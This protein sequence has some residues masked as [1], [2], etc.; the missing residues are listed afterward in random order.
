MKHVRQT[1]KQNMKHKLNHHDWPVRIATKRCVVGL[2]AAAA[3]FTALPGA[4]AQTP[5]AASQA[6]ATNAQT[7]A[8]YALALLKK[9]ADKLSAA[10]S[11]TVKTVSSAESP[12][13]D[14][15]MITYF[16]T[17]A[18][19]V[20][21]PNKLMVKRTGDGP[22][23]DLYY[24]GKIFGGVD[25]KLGLYARMDAPPTLDG[26][27]SAVMEKTGMSLPYGD[28]L[29]RDVFA[30][31]TN[32]LTYADAVGQVTINGVPCE[33]LIFAG[34][35]IEW[36]IWLGPE[37]DPLPRRMAVTYLDVER[38]PRFLMNFSDWNLKARLAAS[39]FELKPPSGAKLIE[40]RPH[41]TKTKH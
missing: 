9:S 36:Q 19:A 24:D 33:H 29:Y 7:P 39:R 31:L 40:F 34:P 41:P 16:S 12:S 23:F 11:F 13:P 35:D 32:G 25:T 37:K 18:V 10:K 15:R 30:A 21:R 22:A 20:G 27:M 3:L 6:A 2:A 17:A 28:F 26:L 14:G 38:Q 8:Q 4:H 1:T 5:A